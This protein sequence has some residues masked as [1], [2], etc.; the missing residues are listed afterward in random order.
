M[1]KT[2]YGY[3]TRRTESSRVDLVDVRANPKTPVFGRYGAVMVRYGKTMKGG[4]PKRRTVLT[5]LTVPELVRRSPTRR[6]AA[7]TS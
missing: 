7:G 2:V 4:P 5:V 1:I 3:G 6:W